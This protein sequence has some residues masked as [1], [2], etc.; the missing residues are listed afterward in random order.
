M[1][2]SIQRLTRSPCGYAALRDVSTHEV[3]VS[4]P[5][6]LDLPRARIRTRTHTHANTEAHIH[7]RKRAA[8]REIKGFG[9]V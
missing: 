5:T 3:E 9:F 8:Q 2:E 6:I 4:Q 1:F 7:A